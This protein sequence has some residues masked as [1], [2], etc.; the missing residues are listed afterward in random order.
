MWSDLAPAVLGFQLHIVIDPHG[1]IVAW[2]R[3]TKLIWKYPVKCAQQFVRLVML[4]IMNAIIGR[5]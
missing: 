2:L 1:D 5:P 3:R 4:T